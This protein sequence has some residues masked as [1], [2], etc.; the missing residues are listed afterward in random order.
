MGPGKDATLGKLP[1][2]LKFWWYLQKTPY[3]DKRGNKEHYTGAV[4][5]WEAQNDKLVDC[6]PHTFPKDL[7]G[8]FI[9]QE[10]C[11]RVRDLCNKTSDK[12]HATEDLASLIIRNIYKRNPLSIINDVQGAI[13]VLFKNSRNQTKEFREL[14]SRF[15]T[16]RAVVEDDVAL[17]K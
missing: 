11:G 3:T 1:P 9:E 17:P 15:Y 5:R 10:L 2:R 8:F 14:E 16:Q 12:K 6:I 13:Q 7:R 4:K